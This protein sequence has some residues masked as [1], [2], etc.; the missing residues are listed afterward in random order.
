M[1]EQ[2][3]NALQSQRKSTIINEKLS[4]RGRN[5]YGCCE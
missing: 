2:D 3:N 1:S 5:N 4:I